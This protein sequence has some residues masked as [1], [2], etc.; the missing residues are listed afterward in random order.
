MN[1]RFLKKIFSLS[2]LVFWGFASQ[3]QLSAP[4]SVFTGQTQYPVFSEIDNMFIFCTEKDFPEGSL[5]VETTIGGTKT[6][7]W[8]KYSNLSASFEFYFSESTE[9]MVS[10]ISGLDDGCY[11]VTIT[12][13]A[14]VETYRAWVMNSWFEVA[15]SVTESNCK[16]FQMEGTFTSADL[17][18]YDL[19]DNSEVSLFKD[20]QVMWKKGEEIISRINTP[21]IDEPP[22]Q[23]TEYDYVVYDRFGCEASIKVLYESIVPKASFIIDP[24]EGEAPLE[25]IFTNT[26]ENSDADEYEWF[27]FRDINDIKREAENSS[28]PIDSIME[29]AYNE[30]PVFTYENTGEYMVKLV[31]KKRS[32]FHTCTDTSYLE[33]YIKVDSSFV[34]VPN[35]FTPNGDGD[36]D[37]FV[38]H[39]WSMKEIRVQLFNRWGR[40]VHSWENN[41]VQGF[42]NTVSQ[43][44]WD[45]RMGGRPASPG[46]YYYVIE[47][48]GRDDKKRW[49]HGFFHLIR[50]KK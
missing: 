39:F 30:S 14:T 46:V 27:F 49:A 34:D 45:G 21:Q 7:E 8:Q 13:G 31:A 5:S 3:A 4:G 10:S 18:Y 24:T 47:G 35:F 22:Y 23:D 15:G 33:D 36:N 25:V 28:A 20:I 37:E 29:Y 32:E 16:Y 19:A 26:S 6:F 2:V 40:V 11:Q 38:V 43:S 12:Q 48:L 50:E 9:N 41:N 1:F 17:K 42:E 44:I